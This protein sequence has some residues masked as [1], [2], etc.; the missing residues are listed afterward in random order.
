M[1]A[2]HD[3]FQPM[4]AECFR[5]DEQF[6]NVRP[7]I[8]HYCSVNT[9]EAVVKNEEMWFSNPLYMNDFEELTFGM[10]HSRNKIRQNESIRQ[11]LGTPERYETFRRYIDGIFDQF[12]NGLAFDIYIACFSEHDPA[13][14]DGRLSMWRGYGANGG[15]VALVFNTA[16][17]IE[18]PDSPLRVAKITYGTTEQRLGWIDQ[19]LNRF[20]QIVVS[21]TISEDALFGCAAQ[22]FERLLSFSVFT[23]HSGFQ[24]EQEWRVVYSRHHDQ[25]NALTSMLGY[26]INNGVVEPKLKFKISP[27]E[28]IAAGAMS[29]EQLIVKIIVGPRGASGR[30]KMALQ[31]MLQTLGKHQ[32][33]DLIV[34]SSTPYRE[35]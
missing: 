21:A 17:L 12:E 24:E 20:A 34:T 26:F 31:R 35:R 6:P 27:L 16:A 14:S 29:L 25:S 11:A 2:L 13:D 1:S 10:W 28:G 7:L 9:L 18:V 15:G 32:L 8:A 3:L 19:I 22:L 5:A 4:W 33:A 30:S 23:K